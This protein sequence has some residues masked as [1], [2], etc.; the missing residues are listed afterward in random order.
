M[1]S[2][3]QMR[4]NASM[5]PRFRS[6]PALLLLL[7]Q[8]VSLSAHPHMWIRGRLIPELGRRGLESVRV[9][10]DIDELT[11]AN[12]IL[13]YDTDRNGILDA[14]E[15]DAV[16][17]SAFAHLYDSEYY[18]VVE[19]REMLATPG[20]ARDFTARIERGRII[21]DFRV[22]L[23]VPIRWEDLED[24][25]LYFFDR[26]YFIDFRPELLADTTASWRDASVEF[27]KTS[28]RSMTMG[29]GMVDVIGLTATAVNEG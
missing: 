9:V 12:L 24:V 2:A 1:L 6:I 28:R 21:Y 29:Y 5:N 3:G 10:W 15:S 14:G 7:F 11:S 8:T 26:T 27:R 22:P 16:Y 18:L 4:Y 19:I 25:S 23:S 17:R 20:R 13:D